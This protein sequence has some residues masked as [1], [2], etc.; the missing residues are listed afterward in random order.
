MYFVPKPPTPLAIRRYVELISSACPGGGRPTDLLGLRAET[1][2]AIGELMPL[3]GA[4]QFGACPSLAG[5]GSTVAI[6]TL[7]QAANEDATASSRARQ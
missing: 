2:N 5:D 7:A 6:V 4:H 1:T 3:C